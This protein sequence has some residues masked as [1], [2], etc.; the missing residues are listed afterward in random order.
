[1]QT[2]KTVALL[3]LAV[4]LALLA[5]LKNAWVTE[6]AY[7]LFRSLEQLFAGNGP[8]WNPHERVQVF[9]SP[10]WY[11]VLAF[12]RL[13]SQDNYLMSIIV[14]LVFW[15]ATV[16]VI[17]AII[18]QAG[19]L[20]LAVLLCI[21]SNSFFDYTSSGLENPLGYLVIVGFV[22]YFLKLFSEGETE[23]TANRSFQKIILKLLL[24]YGL[25]IMVRH[26]L[27]LLLFPA[28]IY[29]VFTY[30]RL[31]NWKQW[32]IYGALTFSPFILYSLFSLLYYGFLFPNTAYAKLNTGIPQT[33]LFQ[34]SFN[35][36][37]VTLK[38]DV[39]TMVVIFLA[40]L[41]SFL[42]KSERYF[43]YLGLGL[44][45]NLVYVIYIGGD[46]MLGRFLSYAYLLSVVIL[47]I[48]AAN[49]RIRYQFILVILVILYAV[50]YNHT[51]ANSPIKYKNQ[52][53][54]YGVADERGFYFNDV[55]LYSY[56][57][58]D[59]DAFPQSHWRKQ[60]E[61][62]NHS[63]ETVIVRPTI[64][65]FGYYAGIDKI[66][67]DP[68]ALYPQQRIRCLRNRRLS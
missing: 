43:R 17:H 9:T 61:K 47:A 8:N 36:L 49:L 65:I 6:D 27:A 35:Y 28:M 12:A 4:S 21:A 40:M 50:F 5:F 33:E 57:K 55:S 16:F 24:I 48:K 46:F 14:S 64:G 1:M 10:L 20:L 25:L 2:F 38:Y 45:L 31:Y 32:L 59:R 13:F 62:F 54:E 68:F 51:P 53:I 3:F 67:I 52:V 18:R 66:I 29:A 22:Y 56:V 39:L 26:D 60:A 37:L 19:A 42:P 7:I 44:L 63:E 34:Q 15:L 58:S 23:E 30:R 41:V 11:V